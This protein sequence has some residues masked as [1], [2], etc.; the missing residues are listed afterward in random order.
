MASNLFFLW[1]AAIPL[2]G[3]PGP[4]TMSLAAMGA[5][6]GG[7]RSLQYLIGIIFGTIGVLVLIAT[8]VTAI[9]LAQPVLVSAIT[10]VAVAY[11]LYLA[12]RIATAPLLR[13]ARIGNRSSPAAS[14]TAVKSARCVSSV[15][16]AS[17]RSDRPV[18]RMSNRISR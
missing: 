9:I 16:P 4:A 11:I 15:S 8:G 12:Y 17:V 5:A 7:R 2:M 18:P 1:L 10:V 14:A 13:L 3:S 6:F